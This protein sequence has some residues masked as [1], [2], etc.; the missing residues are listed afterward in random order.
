MNYLIPIA[1]LFLSLLNFAQPSAQIEQLVE[2]PPGP[3][4]NR[5][6]VDS[7]QKAD[8]AFRT[9]ASKKAFEYKLEKE[10]EYFPEV[11][12]GGQ[13]VPCAN[14]GLMETVY[15][16]YAQHRPLALSP[17]AIWAAICQG[18]SIHINE[19][20][21][22]L[23]STIFT[24]N[25]P[26]K[27]VV[28][29]DDL[30]DG[31]ENWADLVQSFSDSTRVYVQDD[32]YSFFV[33]DF[34]TTNDFHRTASQITM[35][36]GFSKAFTYVGESGCGI[37]YITLRGEKSD[38]QWI[39]NHLSQL[40]KIGMRRWAR[41]LR[42]V[43]Q[44]FI[45]SYDEGKL[46][47][48][49]WQDIFKNS[50]GYGPTHISGWIIKF[51][52]Y[53]VETGEATLNETTNEFVSEEH[54]APNP[55]IEKYDYLLSTLTTDKFPSGISKIDVIWNNFFEGVTLKKR[56]HSGFFAIK[57]YDDLSL[58]PFISWS[59][60]DENAL[61]SDLD[62]ERPSFWSES[63]GQKTKWTSYPYTDV[64][65]KAIFAPNRFDNHQSS[66][67]YVK[68]Y[69]LKHFDRMYPNLKGSLTGNTVGIIV[70]SNGTIGGVKIDKKVENSGAIAERLESILSNMRD[71][72][73]PAT[74]P[75]L[76]LEFDAPEDYVSFPVKIN[77][78]VSI[79][80]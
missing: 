26:D 51:F 64:E 43:I 1:F 28:R 14:N 77:S 42:P 10:I 25:K 6:S 54:F 29:N 19:H 12:E 21:E 71:N 47:L 17:D 5:F 44:E 76:Q 7:V 69:V 80:F 9:Y 45:N 31:G 41:E 53:I 18:A 52:P 75:S 74:M 2:I 70:L 22:D 49:F 73:K 50:T 37:P 20:F 56:L 3:V 36:E 34:S 13:F 63:T 46:N 48:E 23:E 38:W 11:Q 59:L 68:N 65:D 35:L 66:V 24:A 32:Y 60:C 58:E 27:I 4:G 67:K 40:E 57:Q 61:K 30:V 72:W 39:H 16:S 78:V 79:Q 33:P 15:L 62:L 55:Y 8:E